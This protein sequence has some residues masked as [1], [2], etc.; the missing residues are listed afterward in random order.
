MLVQIPDLLLAFK[1][2]CILKYTDLGYI[3]I[4]ENLRRRV[5]ITLSDIYNQTLQFYLHK[6]G[7]I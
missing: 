5:L 2:V 4:D 7:N 1:R 3:R 6:K